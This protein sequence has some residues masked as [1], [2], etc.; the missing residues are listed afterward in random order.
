[1]TRQAAHVPSKIGRP[2][3]K[4]DGGIYVTVTWTRPED[5]GG[6]D[7]TA[8][9][10]KYGDIDD[11]AKVKVDGDTTNFKFTDQLEKLTRYQFAVAAV[12]TA[13]QGEFSE[14]SDYVNTE[15]GK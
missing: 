12:N 15:E 7:I 4:C 2:V 9:V 3:G 1:M 10:I 6:G 14:F 13:G 8:Y 11:Y 5:D